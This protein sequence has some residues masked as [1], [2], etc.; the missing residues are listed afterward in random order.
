MPRRKKAKTAT[1]SEWLKKLQERVEKLWGDVRE[2][3]RDPEEL[4]DR[5]ESHVKE[6]RN[7]LKELRS[8]VEK[9]TEGLR[10]RVEEIQSKV[11]G[12]I[13]ITTQGDLKEVLQRLDKLEQR[14][15]TRRRRSGGRKTR[16]K[17]QA[18][19]ETA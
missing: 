1:P 4:R 10:G 11:L 18:P 17:R 15:T 9:R 14:V 13:G 19:T 3:Y 16:R 8:E 5:V 12:A 2:S 6:L 7:D